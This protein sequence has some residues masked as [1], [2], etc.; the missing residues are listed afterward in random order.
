MA[1]WR[2][3]DYRTDPLL[4][5]MLRLT[6]Q[7]G[8]RDRSTQSMPINVWEEGAVLVLEAAMPGLRPEDVEV[9]CAE[10][11]MTIQAEVNVAERE[12]LHQELSST[13]YFRQVAMPADC[14]LEE[15]EAHVEHGLL[16]LRVPKTRPKQPE[17]IRIQ[18]NRGSEPRVPGRTVRAKKSIRGAEGP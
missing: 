11:T 6:G 8:Q 13:R 5:E 14:R 9:L 18:V 16:T 2:F 1:D 4:R 12:Y 15:T 7:G 10:T 3:S 17:R